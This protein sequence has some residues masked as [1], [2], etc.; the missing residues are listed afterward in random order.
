[1]DKMD[2]VHNLMEKFRECYPNAYKT[3]GIRSLITQ[4]IRTPDIDLDLFEAIIGKLLG[5]LEENISLR[6]NVGVLRSLYSLQLYMDM[7]DMLL[8]DIDDASEEGLMQY[9]MDERV[10][11]I[12]GYFEGYMLEKHPEV[13]TDN[14][15]ELLTAYQEMLDTIDGTETESYNTEQTENNGVIDLG[16]RSE[17]K[18]S[19]NDIAVERDTVKSNTEDTLLGWGTIADRDKCDNDFED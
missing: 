7:A 8:A 5:T 1:M 16:T 9:L 17:V 4:L 2:T 10:K 15:E 3:A 11:R 18:L 19:D 12:E 6:K 13:S 14:V